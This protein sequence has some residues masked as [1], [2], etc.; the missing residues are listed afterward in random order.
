MS[1]LPSGTPVR[2]GPSIVKIVLV[3]VA[4]IVV[5]FVLLVGAVMFLGG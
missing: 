1:N 4:D 2:T 3:M 5:V